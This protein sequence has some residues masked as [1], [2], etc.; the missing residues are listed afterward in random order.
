MEF[1]FE[2]VE[3]AEEHRL[4]GHGEFGRAEFELAVVGEDHVFDEEPELGRKGVAGRGGVELGDFFLEE[5]LRYR[6]VADELA[7]EGVVEGVAPG[8]LADF[9]YVVEDGAGEEQIG[10]DFGVEGRGGEADAG[11]ME[12]MLEE[13]PD[14]GVVEALGGRGFEE[15]GAKGW[16]VEEGEDEAAE[17]GVAEGLDVGAELGGHGGDVVLGGGDEVGGVD[18][19]GGGETHPGEGDLELALVLGDL[20]LDFDIA[21]GGAGLKGA[22]EVV[23]HAGFELAGLVGEGDC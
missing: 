9:A 6:D 12:D 4:G 13:A 3:G 16:V 11:Q 1:G 7:F 8:E 22:G 23:P 21:A 5:A 20:A 18:L 17:V 19:G 15:L 2:V 14:P 10:I